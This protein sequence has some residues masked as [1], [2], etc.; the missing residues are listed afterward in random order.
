MVIL[1]VMVNVDHF[2]DSLTPGNW[3]TN[4]SWERLYPLIA[5]IEITG[6][7]HSL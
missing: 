6:H 7:A 4:P 5:S 2:I 1:Y 3:V